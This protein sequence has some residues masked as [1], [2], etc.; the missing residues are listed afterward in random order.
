MRLIVNPGSELRGGNTSSRNRSLTSS[1]LD[2][3]NLDNTM[4]LL[5][6]R[7][8]VI[9]FKSIETI[10]RGITFDI[11]VEVTNKYAYSFQT[12]SACHGN[13]F[14]IEKCS[15]TF[16]TDMIFKILE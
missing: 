8:A 6:Y 13:V 12:I 14:T 9:Q 10:R 3:F 2:I 4:D 15:W 11:P 1:D 16:H 7:G 5:I